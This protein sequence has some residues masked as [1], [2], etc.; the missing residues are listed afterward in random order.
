LPYEE[1]QVIEAAAISGYLFWDEAIV[2]M[3]FPDNEMSP[4]VLQLTLT[5]LEQKGFI[6][7]QRS[8]ILVGTSEFVF[9]HDLLMDAIYAQIAPSIRQAYHGRLADWL[10]ARMKPQHLSLYS[11]LIVMHYQKAGRT[12]MGTQWSAQRGDGR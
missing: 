8:S 6:L 5:A 2:G 10:V 4:E 1:K 7:R 11:P 9:I 3:L 12:D